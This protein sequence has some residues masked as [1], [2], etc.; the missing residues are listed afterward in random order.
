MFGGA[1]I[2]RD[3]VMFALVA[4]ETLYLKVGAENQDRFAAAGLDHFAYE[5][6]GKRMVMS[7]AQAPEAAL[8]D[9][10]ILRD[11]AEGALAEARKAGLT[12]RRNPSSPEYG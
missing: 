2:F 1:G 3:G 4:D 7:Y 9:P 12:R 6:K 10:D 8:E 5:A 11:W